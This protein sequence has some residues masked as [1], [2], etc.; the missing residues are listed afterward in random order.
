MSCFRLSRIC[1]ASEPVS[2]NAFVWIIFVPFVMTTRKI[3]ENALLKLKWLEVTVSFGLVGGV[4]WTGGGGL[5]AVMV[6]LCRYV[7]MY[8]DI[9]C[10]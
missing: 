5:V 8:D 3:C 1:V 4:W 7:V 6:W 9:Y 2:I 10:S